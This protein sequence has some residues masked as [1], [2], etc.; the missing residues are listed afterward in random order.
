[1]I[2][3]CTAYLSSLTI[4]LGLM[5][6][7]Y[8]LEGVCG[9]PLSTLS[10]YP[11]EAASTG[12]G[13][14]ERVFHGI[15]HSPFVTGWIMERPVLRVAVGIRAAVGPYAPNVYFKPTVYLLVSN[16]FLDLWLMQIFK[17]TLRVPRCFSSFM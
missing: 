2:Y 5:K 3:I 12:E 10:F 15:W 4:H 8:Q 11:S 7:F 1:M 13:G 6:V 17:V 14:A 9:N 16:K